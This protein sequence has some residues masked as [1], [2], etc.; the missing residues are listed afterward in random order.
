MKLGRRRF[1]PEARAVLLVAACVACYAN[2]VTG[3][4]TYDDKAIVRDD[5]RLRSPARLASIFTTSYFGGPRGQGTGYRPILLL[6]YAI[7][8][9]LHGGAVF[10]FHVVNVALHILVTLLFAR[11]LA[12]LG[13]GGPVA[14]GAAL[15]FAVHPIHVEAVTSLV[16]RGETLAAAFVLGMLL[17][18]LR[19]RREAKARGRVL[20]LLVLFYALGILSKESAVIAPALVLL[21][22]WRLETGAP[23]ERLKRA[24][25]VALPIA[26]CCAVVL[27]GSLAARRVVLGGVIKASTFRIFEVENP[28]AHVSTGERVMNA[29]AILFRYVGRMIVPL[30]LS[31]DESAWSIPVVH[32]FN[33]VGLAALVLGAALLIAAVA[34]EREHMDVAFGVLFFAL[35]FVTTS[36]LFFPIGT[37]LAER[38]AYLPSAGFALALSTALLGRPS[39]AAPSSRRGAIFLTIVLLY[40]ARTVVRNPVWDS[41]DRLF[42]DTALSSP[43]SAKAHYNLGWISAERGKFPLA[44]EEYTRATRIYP[45]YFDAWAG[46]GNA[47][48]HLGRLADA[49]R[50]FTQAIAVH[51]GYENGFFRLGSVR[52][53]RGNL[54]GA[55]EAFAEGLAKNPKSMPLA[56]RLAKVRSRLGR[57]SADADWRRALSLGPDAVPFHLGYAQFLAGQG[58]IAEARR[59]ARE[60]LRRRPRDLSAL[61]ILADSSGASG[62]R[63]SEGLAAEK[64]FRATRSRQDFD[65]LVRIAAADPSYRLRFATVE[66]ALRKT[67]DQ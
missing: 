23:A 52:E 13:V 42:A 36:N 34:R 41:D 56:Y 50:S 11:L 28:L 18:A 30:R 49:E 15:L 35:A 54:G 48:Q 55:E 39:E 14:F 20:A 38:V 46:K 33:P 64:I 3:D 27:A 53:M 43:A 8:W 63:L 19:Y 1:L 61:T 57:P 29:A 5:V 26:G 10:G 51:P 22:Y 66:P 2:G 4:Y 67:L 17:L 45:R 31:A 24:L 60:V 7:Q 12:R 47:E 32:G 65:R 25:T 58:R 21:T 16:G 44:L 40:A 6:S 9:W 37:I 62:R 59:E